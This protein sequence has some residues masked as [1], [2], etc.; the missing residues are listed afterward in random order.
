VGRSESDLGGTVPFLI[1]LI[2]IVVCDY[3]PFPVFTHTHN[4]DD[5]LRIVTHCRLGKMLILS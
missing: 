5:T 1:L 3:I 2:D 4:G